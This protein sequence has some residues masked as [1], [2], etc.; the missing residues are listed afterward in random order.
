MTTE[1]NVPTKEPDTKAKKND[2]RK[3]KKFFTFTLCLSIVT[4]GSMQGFSLLF[5]TEPLALLTSTIS[6]GQLGTTLEGS[7]TAS[8][9]EIQSIPLNSSGEILA[10]Y[11]SAG[12]I[13]QEGQLLYTQD[14]S[15][16]DEAILVL[17][18]EIDAYSDSIE[19]Y[20]E[21]IDGY[22]DTI[23][24]YN[25]NILDYRNDIMVYEKNIVDLQEDIQNLTVTAPFTGK[26]TDIAV[27]S[28]DSVNSN[29]TLATLSN[30]TELSVDLYFSYTYENDISIG[31]S[32]NISIP[33]M[34]LSLKGAVSEIT[35]VEY[36][37]KEG[38]K[39]FLVRISVP[40]SGSLAS[41]MKVS[42][43][44]GDKYPV[45]AGILGNSQEVT[46][47]SPSSAYVEE[48][49]VSNYQNI[50]VGDALFLLD[51]SSL[52]EELSSLY[53]S[54][55]DVEKNIL[56]LEKNISS[57]QSSIGKQMDKVAKEEDEIADIYL[58]IAELE[59][60]RKDFMVYSE[61]SGKIITVNIEEGV[62]PSLLLPAVIIYNLDTMT[63][64][65]NI[66]ELDVEHV[67]IGM[68]VT[69]TYSTSG[70]TQNYIGKIT[71]ISYEAN[72]ESGVAYFPVTISVDTMGELSS[73]V[74]ISY[75]ISIGDADEGFL[76]P[77]DAIKSHD[78]GTCIY[79]EGS[80]TTGLIVDDLPEGYYALDVTVETSDSQ[81]ALIFTEFGELTEGMTVFT[82]Y[83]ATEPNNGD[84]TSAISGTGEMD[85]DAMM[86][87]RE[88]MMGTGG[89]ASGGIG[90]GV[91]A[92]N[93][94]KTSIRGG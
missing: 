36:I 33:D 67:S 93:S 83:Q 89:M 53:D 31:D 82:R 48:V 32:A 74:S 85:M 11:V 40:N 26:I 78:N 77:I 56:N 94:N 15:E 60:S 79:V 42:A 91:V 9:A 24:D 59:K 19:E 52:E 39:C 1:Q 76:V 63:F 58:E 87:M 37:T 73:G 92:G 90:N 68:P 50:Q 13:I 18:D 35:K 16:V 23:S 28:G 10:V 86:A 84:V 70:N 51:S 2:N 5:A 6:Y 75:K 88:S 71:A 14:D 44:I 43:T 22:Y 38:T 34:M 4:A 57:T 12:E 66:D 47:L 61:I 72:N 17:E 30:N 55:S 65:A 3:I 27:K 45:E 41:G 81:N 7:G 54:I 62:S 8:S 80:S 29:D 21:V 69:I 64:T 49:F 20:Y 25:D 46:V